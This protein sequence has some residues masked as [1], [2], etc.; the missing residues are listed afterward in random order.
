MFQIRHIKSQFSQLYP[1]ASL[2]KFK[3]RRIKKPFLSFYPPA[4]PARFRNRHIK[5]QFS[6]FYPPR[7]IKKPHSS[8]H[9]TSP[10]D[11][12]PSVWPWAA[13]GRPQSHR[14]AT[15]KTG[16]VQYRPGFKSLK[17]S[18]SYSLKKSIASVI[19]LLVSLISVA[20]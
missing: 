11:A 6:K 13:C 14:T 12:F 1:P 5:S 19:S 3:I 18:L 4:A 20:E 2:V 8:L 7:S 15:K 10:Q 9:N 16:A 17:L